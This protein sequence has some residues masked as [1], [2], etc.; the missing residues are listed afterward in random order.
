MTRVD[1]GRTALTIQLRRSRL[2]APIDP[3]R[4]VE[5][6]GMA[7]VPVLTLTIDCE[8]KRVGMEMRFLID[9]DAPRRVPDRS[10]KRLLAQ[11]Q[12]FQE[13]VL[14]GDGRSITALATEAG[15]GDSYFSRLLRLSFLAPDIV[16][17]VLAN[18][19]PIQL[20]AQ[21]LVTLGDLPIA[22]TDQ[23]TCLGI[24]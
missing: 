24:G 9:G 2:P 7:E 11:A 19:H 5:Q 1:L 23:R 3:Q 22:W 20:N 13:M 18:R 12:R 16:A 21:R 14:R 10:L 6:P 15:V 8:L 17:E 4:I